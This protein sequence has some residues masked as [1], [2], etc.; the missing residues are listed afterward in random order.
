[1]SLSVQEWH[2][3]FSLQARWT[4]PLRSFLYSRAG[5]DGAA[6]VLDVG[7]GTGALQGELSQYLSMQVHG[8][9][10]DPALLA[11]AVRNHPRSIFTLADANA[12]PYVGGSFDLTLCHYL[13]LWVADPRQVLLEMRRLTRPGGALLVLAEPDYGGRVD[14]P[15]ELAELGCLQAA[16]LRQQGAEPESGRRL[17]GLFSSLGLDSV[18]TGVLG[19]QWS[20][21]LSI[22]EL[23]SEWAVLRSDLQGWLSPEQFEQLRHLDEKSWQRGERV[24]FVP[25]FYAFGRLPG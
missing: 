9:D 3:R 16:S 20:G 11:E 23:E 5:L 7:C 14:Y 12:M 1:M 18:E 25:T 22:Q 19:A 6:R 17:I 4:Q 24:L 13:L 21:P 10:L 2:A 8:L 15:V